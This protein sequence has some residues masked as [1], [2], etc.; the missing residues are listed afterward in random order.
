MNA[1]PL[2]QQSLQALQNLDLR[3]LRLIGIG[4]IALLLAA[5]LM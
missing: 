1:T 3:Q 4:V 2:Q 5:L